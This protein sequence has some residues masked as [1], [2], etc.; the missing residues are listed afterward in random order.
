MPP[1]LVKQKNG[2]STFYRCIECRRGLAMRILSI[3]PS[4]SL[5]VTRVDCDKTI[6]R[7]DQ[8]YTA[9]RKNI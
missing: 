2:V 6:E 5:S 4:V 1:Y 9:L 8:I 3:R 7:S